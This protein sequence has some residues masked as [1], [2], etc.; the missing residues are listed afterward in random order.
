MTESPFRFY[1]FCTLSQNII[2]SSHPTFAKS[3]CC[4]SASRFFFHDEKGSEK[5]S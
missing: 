2:R 3:D 1:F 4:V 5:S